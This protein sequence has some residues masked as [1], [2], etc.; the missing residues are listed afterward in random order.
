M[1]HFGTPGTHLGQPSEFRKCRV[2]PP[3]VSASR[4]TP[5]TARNA[6]N[7]KGNLTAII[8][9]LILAALGFVAVKVVPCL[10]NEY[11]FQDGIQDI[12]RYASAM[13]QD[14][15]KV[16]E[17]VLKEAEKD[18]V[19]IT[20]KDLKIVG[21]GGNFRISA[22]YSVTVDLKVYQWTLDFHPSV[23]NNSLT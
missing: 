5:A 18:D 7:G 17:A 22:D 20:T 3:T 2:E 14:T 4:T 16:R 19:P 8:F 11:Q 15:G 6:Q 21:T 10:F 9:T 12:A 1:M 23:S 13:H